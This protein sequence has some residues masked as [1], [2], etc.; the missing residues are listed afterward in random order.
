LAILVFVVAIGNAK[1]FPNGPSLAALRQLLTQGAAPQHESAKDKS[2]GI[3][4]ASAPSPAPSFQL[5]AVAAKNGVIRRREEEHH[6]VIAS[7]SAI[8]G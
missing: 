4:T 3:D 2:A 6:C 1:F 5:K 7:P 8:L